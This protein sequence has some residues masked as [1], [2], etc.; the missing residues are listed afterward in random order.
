M[1]CLYWSETP[2]EEPARV[3]E[4]G[5]ARLVCLASI[6][7]DPHLPPPWGPVCVEWTGPAPPALAR[8][9]Y[10]LVGPPCQ[11]VYGLP[12]SERVQT[13]KVLPRKWSVCLVVI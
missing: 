1:K 7:G 10:G 12:Q 2:S 3:E 13:V 9:W 8:M 11:S 5:A 4:C 6:G